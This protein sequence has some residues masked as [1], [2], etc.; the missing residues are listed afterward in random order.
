MSLET[1][2]PAV[3][4]ASTRFT[5]ALE[6]RVL[7]Y[8][9]MHNVLLEG[10]RTV[11]GVSGGPDSAALLVLLS[12]LS[13]KLRLDITVV[14]FDHQLR[15]E[16]EVAGDLDFV[17]SL[18]SALSLPF[19]LGSG[20]V[21]DYAK[22][23]R[24]SLEDAA[25]RLR[26]EF[27]WEQAATVDAPAIAV[28][29]TLNDQA[30]TILLHL[31][32]GAGLTGIAGMAARAPWPFG[33]GPQLSRPLL[34]VR[35]D[36]T[37]RYCRELGV[38]PRIDSTNQLMASRRNQVRNE[39]LPLL[40]RLNPRIEESLARFATAAAGDDLYLDELARHAF[41]RLAETAGT[42]V[43]LSR[44]D[45]SLL[46]HALAARVI[47]LAFA[48][49]TGTSAD[50]EAAHVDTIIDSLNGP[51]GTYSLAAGTVATL[52][53]V[54]VTLSR[55]TLPGADRMS[56]VAL[57][58]PGRTTAGTW[59]IDAS[60]EALPANSLTRNPLEAY[61]DADKIADN[62]T[63]RSRRPGDRLRPLGLGG[64]K[65]VQDILVD[66]KVPARERD[67]VP[68]VCAGDQIA[69]VVGH[70]IDERFALTAGTRGA[71]HIIFQHAKSR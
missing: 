30:E 7:R 11:V 36:E 29:H 5:T 54:S 23:H 53:S 70:C 65:K 39:V 12:R 59:L 24:L 2:P 37:E 27:L 22:E 14:H 34:G 58:V 32:R 56:E 49:L 26:Y 19:V 52:D 33:G 17:R 50:L 61:L 25:R 31:I 68:I 38:E 63:V 6:R 28:G 66:A 60:I 41:H 67:G 35:R 43:R 13:P 55:G 57:S 8:I 71:L 47:R 40:R 1:M 3:S 16:E 51:P 42:T 18:A 9:R 20:N 10:E 62:V 48:Q 64:E 46:P 44:R 15:G 4:L 21:R 45:L 69:W